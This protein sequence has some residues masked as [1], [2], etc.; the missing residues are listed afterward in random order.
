[1]GEI[2]YLS[3]SALQLHTPIRVQV[4]VKSVLAWITDEFNDRFID[5]LSSLRR[6]ILFTKVY[7]K[8][9]FFDELSSG[10]HRPNIVF[11]PSTKLDDLLNDSEV[12][13]IESFISSYNPVGR[14]L[15]MSGDSVKYVHRFRD[16]L[17]VKYVGSMPMGKRY[18]IKKIKVVTN[19]TVTEGFVDN[20]LN[21]TGR[22]IRV[23]PEDSIPLAYFVNSKD[24]R[25]HEEKGESTHYDSEFEHPAITVSTY[26][27]GSGVLFAFDLGLT[28]TTNLTSFEWLTIVGQA[29]D[30]VSQ[31][32]NVTP[33]LDIEIEIHPKEHDAEKARKGNHKSE[34]E[35]HRPKSKNI[36]VEVKIENT[37]RKSVFNLSVVALLQA[38]LTN[39]TFDTFSWNLSELKIDEDAEFRFRANLSNVSEQA[40][41]V[42]VLVTAFD[43]RGNEY[44]FIATET[45]SV[46]FEK[47]KSR[48]MRGKK[49]RR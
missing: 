27:D 30:W 42:M 26:E 12:H 3:E 49:K 35:H 33:L 18:T 9:E 22:A 8:T 31:V 43:S 38:N 40:Y 32:K 20:I 11:F 21:S 24:H 47:N 46:N 39:Q 36:N 4:V 17:G 6:D 2:R 16:I 48:E 25:K 34:D 5:A 45:F 15:I 37:G 23:K 29:I 44:S 28:T 7:N 13:E 19:H 1:M 14:G 41:N 10:K